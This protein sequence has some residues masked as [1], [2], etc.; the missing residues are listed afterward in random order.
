MPNPFEK[1]AD[2][3]IGPS[4][5]D[6]QKMLATV[7]VASLDDLVAG[8]IPTSILDETLELPEALTE[9]VNALAQVTV[10]NGTIRGTGAEGVFL[11]ISARVIDVRVRESGSTAIRGA[12]TR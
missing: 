5:S 3:H 2:R 4:H 8:T 6:I 11:G 12:A 1:F 9:V 10:R 7:G